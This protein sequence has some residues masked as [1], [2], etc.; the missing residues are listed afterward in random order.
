MM[1]ALMLP[2]FKLALF[3]TISLAYGQ[4]QRDENSLWS[5]RK[6][7]PQLS[8]FMDDLDSQEFTKDIVPKGLD[9]I[10][11]RYGKEYEG[12]RNERHLPSIKR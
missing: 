7:Y 2:Y 9:I 8:H 6:H 5:W 12:S 4:H 10:K 11:A 3:H 1:E